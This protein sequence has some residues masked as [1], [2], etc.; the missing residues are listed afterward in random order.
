VKKQYLTIEDGSIRQ[1]WL[2]G[3]EMKIQD[4]KKIYNTDSKY[5]LQSEKQHMKITIQSIDDQSLIGLNEEL[6]KLNV[7]WSNK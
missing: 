3:K 4:I 2:F 5:L 6:I 7:E 1:N